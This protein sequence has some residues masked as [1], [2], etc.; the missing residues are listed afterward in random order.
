M[1]SSLYGPEQLLLV[2]KKPHI[3]DLVRRCMDMSEE[4]IQSLPERND[5]KQ[6]LIN[7]KRF[8][9][10]KDTL[11]N[12]MMDQ[13]LPY[14][15]ITPN[16]A[17]HMPVKIYLYHGDETW[18]KTGNTAVQITPNCYIAVLLDKI[19][20]HFK[21]VI[22]C[23]SHEVIKHLINNSTWQQDGNLMD[24]KKIER[25]RINGLL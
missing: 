15:K 20:I 23:D 2:S 19:Q 10:K 6:G 24:Y 7:I 5:I 3:Q 25:N 4:E 14:I 1:R 9:T 18:V 13:F 21:G 12:R 17:A 8:G 16:I 11:I 22:S